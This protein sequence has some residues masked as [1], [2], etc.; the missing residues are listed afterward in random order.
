VQVGIEINGAVP[1]FRTMTDEELRAII[2]RN[3]PVLEGK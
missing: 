3:P 1:N 2:R